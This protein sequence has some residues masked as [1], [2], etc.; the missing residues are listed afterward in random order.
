M[1]HSQT[2]TKLFTNR[3]QTIER[4]RA[5]FDTHPHIINITDQWLF[6]YNKRK[7]LKKAG[8]DYAWVDERLSILSSKRNIMLDQLVRSY[9]Y[10]YNK[11]GTE[12]ID[13]L[14]DGITA[15]L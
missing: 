8:K 9:L 3:K 4:I 5:L 14:V 11:F 13:G 15:K 7:Q 2:V 10:Y 6:L 12:A 1:N